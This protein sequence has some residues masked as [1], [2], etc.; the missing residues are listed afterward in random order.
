VV[1]L[2][3]FGLLMG[4][5]RTI[6]RWARAWATRGG[7]SQ[8]YFEVFDYYIRKDGRVIPLLKG[9]RDWSKQSRIKP[10]EEII[11]SNRVRNENMLDLLYKL[12]SFEIG[13][14]RVL[15]IGCGGGAQALF[16]GM[17]GAELICATDVTAYYQGSFSRFQTNINQTKK[18]FRAFIKEDTSSFDSVHY[19]LMDGCNLGFPDNCFDLIYSLSVLEHIKQIDRAIEEMVRVVKPGGIMYHVYAPFFCPAA[20]RPPIL[21]FPWGHVI[22]TEEE[23][24]DYLNCFR[25]DE[26][27]EDYYFYKND[28]AKITLDD[29]ER[30]LNESG[31]EVL[32]WEEGQDQRHKKYLSEDVLRAAQENYPRA[33]TR[34]LL[35]SGVTMVLRKQH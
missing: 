1:S 3:R 19:L 32:F 25:K 17:K 22:L 6:L 4:F 13:G 23:F 15:E 30:L 28:F 31:L 20:H 33:T 7:N 12:D 29:F 5:I 24:L 34:D 2:L 18:A 8:K 14:R 21:D 9:Y 35:V 11:N 27:E 26:L 10:D 16:M